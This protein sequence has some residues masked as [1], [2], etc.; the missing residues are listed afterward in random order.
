MQD[1]QAFFHLLHQTTRQISKSF[2]ESLVPLGLHL[3][4]WSVIRFLHQN[5]PCTQRTISS[6][7]NIEPPTMTRTLCRLE[8]LGFITR[9]EGKVDK[10]EKMIHLTNKTM[11][12]IQQWQ[13]IIHVFENDVIDN[14]PTDELKVAYKVFQ[15]MINN[16]QASEK[17]TQGE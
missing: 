3:A 11:D 8:E 2:N 7:L 4:Q 12:Q 17:N 6:Y 9:N 16:M 14:I 5:G 10:R 15:K 1:K 13:E